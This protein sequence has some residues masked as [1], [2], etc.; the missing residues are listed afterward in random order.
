MSN[1]GSPEYCDFA[2]KRAVSA[3]NIAG[4]DIETIQAL[5]TTPRF[6]S[7]GLLDHGNIEELDDAGTTYCTEPVELLMDM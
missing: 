2:N 1:Y 6:D 5:C 4:F 3:S 7:E